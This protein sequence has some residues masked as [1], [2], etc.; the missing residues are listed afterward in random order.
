[1]FL[2]SGLSLDFSLVHLGEVLRAR[3]P[4]SKRRSAPSVP[5]HHVRPGEGV[6][7]T[8]YRG[9]RATDLWRRKR[10]DESR[11]HHRGVS[12]SYK[13]WCD[14]REYHPVRDRMRLGRVRNWKTAL[15]KWYE[16]LCNL[17][18]FNS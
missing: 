16:T 15:Q 12:C 1:M 7:S 5:Q 3:F 18:N 10:P 13:A 14:H 11:R 17:L 4:Q 6:S 8:T 2:R 9:G